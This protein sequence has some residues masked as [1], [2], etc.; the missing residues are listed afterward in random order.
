[1]SAWDG[2]KWGPDV[3]DISQFHNNNKNRNPPLRFKI[4][5]N[6]ANGFTINYQD[7]NIATYPNKFNITNADVLIPKVEPIAGIN[8]SE[9]SSNYTFSSGGMWSGE[10][11]NEYTCLNEPSRNSIGANGDYNRYC[12]FDN[13]NDAKKY[14]D[15]DP[16]C[17][18]YIANSAKNMFTV[19]R[20][21]VQNKG[22]NGNYFRKKLSDPEEERR[23]S[24][25][26]TETERQRQA[27]EAERQA[28]EAERQRILLQWNIKE[29]KVPQYPRSPIKS[30]NAVNLDE[31]KDYC[32][33]LPNC[34]GFTIPN[35]YDGRTWCDLYTNVQDNNLVHRETYNVYEKK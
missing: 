18:G 6:T 2:I 35:N 24:N 32:R 23:V 27:A 12:I 25:M 8:V 26:E 31:C 5:F 22:A 15:S 13:E 29:K 3:W 10:G 33:K 21:P 1:M 9:S 28:A 7:Q 14:C 17:K 16:T 20:K 11:P 19:T 4:I 34:A 30:Y